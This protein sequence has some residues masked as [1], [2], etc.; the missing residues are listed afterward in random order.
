MTTT[1][2]DLDAYFA[3]IGYEGPRDVSVETLHNL[4]AAHVQAIPF[5][6]CDVLLGARIALDTASLQKKLVYDRR[7]GYCFEQNGFFLLMLETLG[8]GV[9]PV[10]AR[11]RINRPR[12]FTP[13]R[14]HLFTRVEINGESWLADVGVGGLSPTAALRLTLNNEQHT[15]HEPRRIIYE[16][17]LYYH[18]AKLGNEWTDIC[19][20]TLETMPPIDR[21]VAS[22]Y[23]ST[24]PQSH[25]KSQLLVARAAPEGQRVTL[26]NNV[27]S[28][29]DAEGDAAKRELTSRQELLDVLA[30]HFGLHFPADTHFELEALPWVAEA[31]GKAA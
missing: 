8:F 11:V 29:R 21:E 28:I 22:W 2:I 3:R 25:F 4:I 9:T 7:G 23:T 27:F 17:N 15:P 20:F 24:H 14:T 18:Q 10:S 13:P 16:N 1:P 31:K 6:N 30:E 12:D 5:E 19:E 26:L